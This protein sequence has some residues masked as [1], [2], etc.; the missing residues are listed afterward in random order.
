MVYKKKS[1]ALFWLIPLLIKQN[2][3]QYR[4]WLISRNKTSYRSG[5]DGRPARGKCTYFTF[6][7]LINTTVM[8]QAK[9]PDPWK[10][11]FFQVYLCRGRPTSVLTIFEIRSAAGV[12]H[13]PYPFTVT[14]NAIYGYT[15]FDTYYVLKSKSRTGTFERKIVDVQV[16]KL[17][18]EYFSD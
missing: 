8:R 9:P 14:Y 16:F 10:G 2:Q 6:V 12:R 17:P 7:L 1:P 3:S 18:F 13:R 4:K 11:T 15:K 5:T